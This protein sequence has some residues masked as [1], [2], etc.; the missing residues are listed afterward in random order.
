M[1]KVKRGISVRFSPSGIHDWVL[2]TFVRQTNLSYI[3]HLCR[4]AWYIMCMCAP[5]LSGMSRSLTAACQI[6]LS[7][8]FPRPEN[9]SR[10][11][12]PSPGALPDPGIERILYHWVTQEPAWYINFLKTQNYYCE[13]LWL[14]YVILLLVEQNTVAGRD[15]SSC[16][17]QSLHFKDGETRFAFTKT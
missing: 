13:P 7:M 14:Y 12:F 10:L 8:G 4:T 1:K 3:K 9:W 2:L 17:E 6:S 15:L 11:L 5:N 16:L